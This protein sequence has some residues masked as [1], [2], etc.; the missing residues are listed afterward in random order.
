M[1]YILETIL[2]SDNRWSGMVTSEDTD[3]GILKEV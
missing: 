1:G 2:H 3:K